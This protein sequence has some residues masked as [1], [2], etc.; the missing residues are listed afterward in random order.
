MKYRFLILAALLMSV[1]SCGGKG[2]VDEPENPAPSVVTTSPQSGISDVVG[3]SLSVLFTFDQNIKCSPEAQSRIKI[4]GGASV[5]S[6][7]VSATDITVKVSGLKPG[8]SYILTLPEGT[9]QGFRNNQKVFPGATFAF[10]T[11]EEEPAPDGWESAV[12]AARNMG[13]GW[14][15]GNTLDSNSGSLDNMWIEAW[16]NRTPSDYETAWGQPVTTR[17]L[18]HMFKAEGFNTIRVPVTWYP[19]IGKVQ[20]SIQKVGGEDK[21]VWD[22][23]TWTGYDVDPAWMA[24]VKE[25]VDYVIDEEMYCVLNVHHDT[26]AET[27]AWLR[28]DPAVYEQQKE[29]FCELWKQIANTFKEYDKHLLFESFNEMLDSKSTWN[30]SSSDAHKTINKYNADFVS[31]VRAT[32]GNNAHR[33]LILNTYAAST[34]PKALADFVLPNDS[35]Q[36]HLLVE[37]HS[38]APYLFAFDVGSGQKTTFDASCENEIKGIFENLNKYFVS[39]G[40]PCVLG[41]YGCT[42]TRAE[43]ERAKQAACYVSNAARYNI[44]CLYWMSLSDG[45]DRLVPK[46]TTPTIKTAILNAWNESQR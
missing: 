2:S 3:K 16:T 45:N 38:Y 9:V 24:R 11:K 7:N 18:I 6:V 43:I 33:N 8:T 29:R 46:W 1:V 12:V 5:E 4:D 30:Y 42:G 44:P 15:L 31:T 20:V 17:E 40:I 35:V 21:P 26:G 36:D 25:I 10:K 13:T 19:H 27:A 23:T 34:D 28:A 32:G 37:V 14:N 39:K 41:E 22:P